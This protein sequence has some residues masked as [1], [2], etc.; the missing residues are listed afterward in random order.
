MKT[1][2]ALAGLLLSTLVTTSAERSAGS[3]SSALSEARDLR[4]RRLATRLEW[5]GQ[6]R[7]D[8]VFNWARRTALGDTRLTSRQRAMLA[9]ALADSVLRKPRERRRQ[10]LVGPEDCDFLLTL[11]GPA[12]VSQVLLS[13]PEAQARWLGPDSAL[14]VAGFE[15][16]AAKTIEVLRQ[17]FPLDSTVQDLPA[18]VGWFLHNPTTIPEGDGVIPWYEGL[19]A[20]INRVR[21][22]H[23]DVEHVQ[24]VFTVHVEALI[25]RHGVVSF[26]RVK[27]GIPLLHELSLECVRRWRYRPAEFEG[28]PFG[29]RLAIPVD[30]TFP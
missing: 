28:R 4:I 3:L 20:L 24:G 14:A 5:P 16:H 6:W 13:F 27:Q 18:A 1:V 19:P 11:R 29:F 15:H 12:G 7:P 22:E 8:S 26:A 23:P 21:C 17:C 2:H 10:E 30:H 25:D 9:K